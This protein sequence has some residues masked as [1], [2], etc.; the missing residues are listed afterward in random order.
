ME[1]GMATH[2]SIVAYRIPRAEEPGGLQSTKSDT[3]ERLG[4]HS[5]YDVSPS[6]FAGIRKLGPG[7]KHG[8]L[9]VFVN[10]VLLE[11]SQAHS[12]TYCLWVLSCNSGRAEQL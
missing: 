1:E 12:F 11:H 3:T 5:R 9:P 10:K 2:S 6:T 4:T 8:L 7:A